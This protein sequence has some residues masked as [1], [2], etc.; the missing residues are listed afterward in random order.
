MNAKLLSIII[1]SYNME[2]YLDKCCNSL[3]LEDDLN[4][5]LEIII[6]NDGSK[7]N[8]LQIARKYVERMPK[9]FKIIDKGNGNYGSCINSGL[10]EAKG[11]FVKILD[12]DDCF[13]T[14]ELKKYIEELDASESK[15]ENVELFITNRVEV[16]EDDNAVE[17]IAFN[18]DENTVFP[19]EKIIIRDKYELTH[20]CMTYRTECL[21]KMCYQQQEG[22]SYTD[23]EWVVLPLLEVKNFKYLSINLYRYLIGRTGQTMEEKIFIKNIWM[24]IEVKKHMLTCYDRYKVLAYETNRVLV[25]RILSQFI[26]SLYAQILIKYKDA[27]RNNYLELKDFDTYLRQNYKHIYV[28]TNDAIY[29]PGYPVHYIH[30]W[31]GTNIISK[32]K[33]K[34]FCH[35]FDLKKSL[36]RH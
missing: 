35:I 10:S 16:D 28:A 19:I 15:N 21:K 2:R 18:Y 8:T 3:I 25:E 34:C 13:N 27:R 1:P 14:E 4:R 26:C 36:C 30:A 32:I 33:Y 29:S 6:V 22:I 31:R 11:I 12:A 5:K 17:K 24:Q 7:D 20:H 9:V 23:Q